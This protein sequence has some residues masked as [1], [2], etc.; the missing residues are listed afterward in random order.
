MLDPD[1]GTEAIF[2]AP[3]RKSKRI[4]ISS[5]EAMVRPLAGKP[6]SMLTTRL[7]SEGF[8][9]QAV[10]SRI[11]CPQRLIPSRPLFAGTLRVEGIRCDG[12]R[13]LAQ[14]VILEGDALFVCV[15]EKSRKRSGFAADMNA[16][17][18][19]SGERIALDM[20]DG[21]CVAR[22]LIGAACGFIGGIAL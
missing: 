2:H 21:E 15:V 11:S 9:T 10:R 22:K 4:R 18:R 16:D 6:I 13:K 20:V 17:P 12:A 8:R 7:P 5:C 19:R 14:Q 1:C 3:G